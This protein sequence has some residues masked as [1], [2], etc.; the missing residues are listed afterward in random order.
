MTTEVDTEV[1]RF[2]EWTQ[3]DGISNITIKKNTFQQNFH[4]NFLTIRSL[5]LGDCEQS[6]SK[7]AGAY[8]QIFELSTMH[9]DS[10]HDGGTV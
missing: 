6:A 3:E 2:P 5:K 4:S 9:H 7:M 10:V 1:E 8:G